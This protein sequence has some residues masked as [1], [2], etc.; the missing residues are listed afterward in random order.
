MAI[1]LSKIGIAAGAKLT[2]PRDIYAALPLRP[3]PYLR[4]EQGE[5]LER[6]YEVRTRRDVVIKQ[7][8]GGGKTAVGLLIAQSSLNEGV[9]PAAYFASDSYL[10]DQVVKE[11]E[12][13]GIAVTRDPRS[14]EF[15]A[16]EAILVATFQRLVNGQSVFGV[17]GGDK[18]LI[19][20][21]TLV[22]DDAH[23]ALGT[24]ESQ[25]SI[26]IPSDQEAYDS[27]LELF[28]DAL[29]RQS[30]ALLREIRE[31]SYTA[32]MRIP[33]WSW[34]NKQDRVLD[35]V[36]PLGDSTP[37]SFQW[38]LVKDQLSF[39]SAIITGRS[40]EIR[41][42]ATPIHKIP[43][44]VNARRRIYM[45]ATLADDGML[46]QDFGADPEL[47]KKPVT[48]K[49]ASDLGD[50][51]ILAPLEL[52]QALTVDSVRQLA[53]NYAKG[54]P[55]A[56]GAPTRA[57]INVVVLVPSNRIGKEWEPYADRVWNVSDLVAGVEELKAGHVGL[58]VLA[59]KYDGI[60]LAD[61]ACRL[62]VVDGLPVALDAVE[63]RESSALMKSRKILA[64]QVQRVEQGM[65]RGVRSGEDYCAVV[66]LGNALTRVVHDP[67]QR[68]LFSPASQAQI[69]L[70]REVAQ[71]L[72]GADLAD[73]REALDL[74]VLHDRDW[75]RKGRER[76]AT[77]LYEPESNL[78]VSAIAERDAFNRIV[79]HDPSGAR[80]TIQ[81]VADTTHDPVERGWL[82]EKAAMYQHAS[83]QVGAQKTL[84]S[85]TTF[86]HHVLHPRAGVKVEKLRPQTQQAHAVMDHY[87]DRFTDRLDA[88]LAVHSL[89]DQFQWMKDSAE[90]DEAAWEALGKL[91]GLSSERPE[92]RYGHGPDNLWIMPNGTALVT[93]LKTGAT[94]SE[95]SKSDVNQLGGSVRWYERKY[96]V[97]AASTPLM[98]HPSAIHDKFSTRPKGARVITFD[99]FARLEDS[100]IEFVVSLSTADWSSAQ[101]I[102]EGLEARNLT[103]NSFLSAY[104]SKMQAP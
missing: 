25:F 8:T 103:G 92:K 35:I 50:R 37:F 32:L 33:F 76:I 39:A 15:I 47:L 30:R 97:D 81:A 58:V 79:A 67:V 24:V 85:A 57:P 22:V 13:M 52:N 73:I 4:L 66:L 82:L 31:G 19:D 68:T 5:V 7:N 93:E 94:S 56:G 21:G 40:I 83:D 80:E 72:K 78:G 100:V 36:A 59:N 102:L 43:S 18:P 46:V 63:R 34:F 87:Q 62:L 61:G 60:D 96:G 71:Q 42:P 26:T 17:D 49:R 104:S 86:N 23:A 69:E 14:P 1:D 3:W 98:L 27:L 48:P 55:D 88:I 64:R 75:V 84:L 51:M 45:T 70:S 89:F 74:C 95:I 65:G 77:S 10:V 6:W 9:G 44:F 16:H 41:P 29:A 54:W 90:E 28:S 20:I 11:A 99:H 12:K 91:L 53:S 2:N 101:S 38:P